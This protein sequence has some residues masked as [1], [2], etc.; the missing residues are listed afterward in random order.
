M[1]IPSGASVIHKQTP[2]IAEYKNFFTARQC[3]AIMKLRKQVGF[4]QGQLRIEGRRQLNIDQR[5]AFTHVVNPQDN[6]ALT[7][8]TPYVADWLS[9]PNI[10]WIENSLFIHYPPDGEFKLHTDVVS[11]QL[12]NGSRTHRVA[13]LIVYIND[14]YQ[15]GCTEFPMH[16]IKINPE[17][18]KALLF[19]YNYTDSRINDT[20]VHLGQKVATNKYI[21]VF[22]IRDQEYP[23]FMRAN[24]YY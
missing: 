10:N 9:L 8:W 14:D 1:I 2:Y 12:D 24:S 20:T 19:C 3:K 11:N 6:I 15:D 17:V 21:M 18:G 4:T 22:F 23:D 16:N 13:T 7:R 5:N